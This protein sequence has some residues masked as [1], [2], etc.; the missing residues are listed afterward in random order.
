MRRILI[1]ILGAP[2]LGFLG[3]M[4]ASFSVA[5]HPNWSFLLI[6]VMFTFF[7]GTVPALLTGTVD[8]YL[9]PKLTL[10]PRILA[11][12]LAGYLITVLAGLLM[13]DRKM[14]PFADVLEFGFIGVVPAVI[15]SWLSG[16]HK[17]LA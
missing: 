8:W 17:E 1:F 10:L 14:T 13:F 5:G 2:V 12:G 15:C 4:V 7:I 11:T 6:I 16:N 3:F 9:A